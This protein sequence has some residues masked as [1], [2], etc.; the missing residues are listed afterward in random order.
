MIKY[1]LQPRMFVGHM[2]GMLELMGPYHEVEGQVVLLNRG[3][4]RVHL[5]DG[6][7]NGDKKEQALP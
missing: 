7:R 3:E 6:K 2:T 1:E 5:W 4:G